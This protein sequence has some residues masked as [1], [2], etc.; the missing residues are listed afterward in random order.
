MTDL[1]FYRLRRHVLNNQHGLRD[2]REAKLHCS[3]GYPPERNRKF[4]EI[5]TDNLSTHHVSPIF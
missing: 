3:S 5:Q 2:D 1:L 4:T